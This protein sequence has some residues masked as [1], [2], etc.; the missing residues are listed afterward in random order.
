[1]LLRTALT[2]NNIEALIGA[3]SQGLGLAYLPDFMVREA[4]ASGQLCSVLDR[5][6]QST[7]KF[8]VLWPSS[9]HLSPKL[10]VFVDFLHEHLRF[11]RA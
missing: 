9:R 4:I 8:W 11:S 1:M 2:C 6:L 3:A 10:R 7:S 5:Y